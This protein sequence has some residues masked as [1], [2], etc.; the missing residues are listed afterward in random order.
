MKKK[1]VL[2]ALCVSMI[3]ASGI[4][5]SAE[6]SESHSQWAEESLISAD[7][8]G[9]LPNFFAD[10]DLTANISRIDFCHLAYKMLEQKS[11]ISE[12]NVKSSFADTDDKEVT[13]LANSGIINGRSETEFAPNDDITREE[14]AVILTN[15]AEFMGVKEDIALFD[16]VF[17][18]YDTVSDWAKESVRKMDSL[19]IMRG[20]GDNNFSPKSNYTMEQS[21]VTMLKLFN[22]DVSDYA[23]NVYEVKIDGDLSLFSGEDKQ[24]IKKDGKTIFTYDGPE[25]NT[26][27]NER[28]FIFFEKSGKWYYYIHNNKSNVSA[29]YNKCSDIYS[30]ETGETVYKLNAVLLQSNKKDTVD[31][32]DDYYRVIKHSEYGGEGAFS[33]EGMKVYSYDGEEIASSSYD[34]KNGGGSLDTSAYPCNNRQIRIDFEKVDTDSAEYWV[35]GENLLAKYPYTYKEYGNS[36]AV[37]EPI[38]Y[39]ATDTLKGYTPVKL[40]VSD[41]NGNNYAVFNADGIP[42]YKSN[43]EIFTMIYEGDLCIGEIKG[44]SIQVSDAKKNQYITTLEWD[45]DK[46]NTVDKYVHE[47]LAKNIESECFSPN[48]SYTVHGY[49][50]LKCSSYSLYTFWKEKEF[51]GYTPV[52]TYYGDGEEYRDRYFL[53]NPDGKIIVESSWKIYLIEYDGRACYTTERVEPN[54]QY[55]SGEKVYTDVYDLKTGE[56]VA[57][58]NYINVENYMK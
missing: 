50:M 36:Q 20:V 57:K 41:W 51:S 26:L 30:A 46:Y 4:G 17:S 53:Y 21:E 35:P 43:T 18:D 16:T 27:D 55:W 19:G 45:K 22:L 25:D 34:S 47:Y 8:A 42:V 33:V 23:S 10:R 29:G 54:D 37:R 32:A 2:G 31:F 40:S 7:E 28:S 14:A 24:W 1:F 6:V 39:I 5:A 44:D 58:P 13:F 56:L 15:T 9:L 49:N 52:Y 3:L 38:S 11:L 48:G 12:N